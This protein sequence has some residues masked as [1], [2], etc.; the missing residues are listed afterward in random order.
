MDKRIKIIGISAIVVFSVLFTVL[1]AIVIIRP[2]IIE[3]EILQKQIQQDAIS[4][5]QK[6][7]S[8]YRAVTVATDSILWKHHVDSLTYVAK[9]ESIKNK[10]IQKVKKY[11]SR[12]A[13]IDT[14][15]D[16]QLN[17]AF[18]TREMLSDSAS[19]LW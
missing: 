17:S 15:N 8:V 16:V 19:Q 1:I 3:N 4:D 9:T 14:L 10:F 13:D 12:L 18:S 2:K 5:K 7:D 11:E 6:G